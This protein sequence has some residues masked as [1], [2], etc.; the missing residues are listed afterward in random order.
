MSGETR[1]TGRWAANEASSGRGRGCGTPFW[2]SSAPGMMFSMIIVV[3][4]MF[5]ILNLVI[6][7][8]KGV[9]F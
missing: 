2:S 7:S 5:S 8:E 6:V 3:A 1:R 9:E 4:R